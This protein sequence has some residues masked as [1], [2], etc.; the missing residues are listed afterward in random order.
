MRAIINK[1]R[2]KARHILHLDESPR[3]LAQA[4]A[5]GVFV[6]FSP[7]LGFHTVMVLLLAWAFRL[8]KIAALAGT[9]INNP[10]TIAFVYIGPTWLMVVVEKAM[11]VEMPPFNYETLQEQFVR[12]TEMY[13]VWQPIFWKTFAAEF[14]PYIHAFVI[15]TCIAGLIAAVIA[16]FAAYF[17]IKYYRKTRKLIHNEVK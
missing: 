16:Y 11:G 8:N 4:F 10:W 1:I 12:T 9:F 2:Q 5:V 3:N 13:Q 15:G 17:G 14:R 6:G 7:F